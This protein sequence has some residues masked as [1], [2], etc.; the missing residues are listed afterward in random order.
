[1]TRK[2]LALAAALAIFAPASAS[3]AAPTEADIQTFER[4]R[5]LAPYTTELPDGRRHIGLFAPTVETSAVS[6]T[7]QGEVYACT[8]RSR[9]REMLGP[10]F[11]EWETR[12]ERLAWRDNCLVRADSADL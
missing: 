9:F 1:M 3:A 6:C 2:P 4:S 7:A 5:I 12:T 10:D 8:Y 11:S